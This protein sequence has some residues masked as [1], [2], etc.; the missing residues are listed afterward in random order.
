ME[1][2]KHSPARNH[3][4]FQMR[5]GDVVGRQMGFRSFLTQLAEVL[6]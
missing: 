3:G 4:A 1:Q 2:R 5:L 6:S